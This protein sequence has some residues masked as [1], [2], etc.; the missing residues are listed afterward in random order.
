M[1]LLTIL[2][3]QQPAGTE[4][5]LKSKAKSRKGSPH[6]EMKLVSEQFGGRGVATFGASNNGDEWNGSYP[7]QEWEFGKGK[8]GR[9]GGG[10][11]FATQDVSIHAQKVRISQ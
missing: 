6:P 11:V 7:N 10:D 4:R 8:K 1:L 9:W 5:E 3:K 2:T